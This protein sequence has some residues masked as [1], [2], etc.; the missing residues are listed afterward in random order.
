MFP[1]GSGLKTIA[2]SVVSSTFIVRTAVAVLP[3]AP[4]AVHVT[5]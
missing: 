2:G 4:V 5:V 1:L 3:N